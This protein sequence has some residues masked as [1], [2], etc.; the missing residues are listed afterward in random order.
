LKASVCDEYLDQIFARFSSRVEVFYLF[1]TKTFS[2]RGY[3]Y[4]DDWGAK[5]QEQMGQDEFVFRR[6]AR[7]LA[8]DVLPA[9]HFICVAAGCKV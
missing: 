5:R 7:F 3:G 1:L 9:H 4:I 8:G 6:G 2:S